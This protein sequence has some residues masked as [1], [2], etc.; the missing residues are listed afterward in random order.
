M[1][2]YFVHRDDSI[3]YCYCR[4]KTARKT[5]KRSNRS[6]GRHY[7]FIEWARNSLKCFLF[8]LYHM[9]KLKEMIKIYFTNMESMKKTF[10]TSFF[11]ILFFYKSK[12]PH[13]HP[14]LH[15]L[16]LKS[17]LFV[18]L[19]IYLDITTKIQGVKTGNS[20]NE[21][22]EVGLFWKEFLWGKVTTTAPDISQRG[23]KTGYK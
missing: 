6:T 10:P 18:P 17:E 21:N 8:L 22:V 4:L 13:I 14:T 16:F 5:T 1:L 12:W 7:Q 23:N 19:K 9:M 15:C 2:L 3:F 11:N 20:K